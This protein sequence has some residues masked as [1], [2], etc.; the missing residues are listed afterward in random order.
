MPTKFTGGTYDCVVTSCYPKQMKNKKTGKLKDVF[1]LT[2]KPMNR[3]DL[4]DQAHPVDEEKRGQYDEDMTLF[5]DI[6]PDNDDPNWQITRNTEWLRSSFGIADLIDLVP[7]TSGYKDVVG[8]VVKL[9]CDGTYWNPYFTSTAAATNAK[10]NCDTSAGARLA[11]TARAVVPS[12]SPV[13]TPS[14]SGFYSGDSAPQNTPE[15]A[16]VPF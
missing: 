14:T 2:H 1:V 8:T 12:A 9:S 16:A 11:A 4:T 10:K 7:E 3:Y 5:F 13:E 6:Y 15:P